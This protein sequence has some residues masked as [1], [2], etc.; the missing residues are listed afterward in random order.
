M[1]F[2]KIYNDASTPESVKEEQKAKEDKKLAESDFAS[3]LDFQ[4][5]QGWLNNPTTQAFLYELE[6]Q[7]REKIELVQKN[8]PFLNEETCR[9]TLVQTD[10]IERIISYVTRKTPIY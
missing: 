6:K 4:N 1:N 8:A 2:K 10:T 9:I 5:Y 7:W 3:S